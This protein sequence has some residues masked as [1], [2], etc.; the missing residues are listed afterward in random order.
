MGGIHARTEEDQ[1]PSGIDPESS[2]E[3]E[4]FTKN[5]RSKQRPCASLGS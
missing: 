1:V 4:Q 3:P 5:G 2:Q